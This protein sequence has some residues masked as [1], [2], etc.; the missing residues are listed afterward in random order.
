MIENKCPHCGASMAAFWHRLTPGL[1]GALIKAIEFV[2]KN[3][4]NEFNL[5]Q[6]D[7]SK[8]EYNNFQ[9]LRFHALVAKVQDKKGSWLIT[10]RGGQF[11]RGEIGVPTEVQTFRNRVISHSDQKVGIGNFKGRY[12]EFQSQFAYEVKPILSPLQLEQQNLL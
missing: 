4:K 5:S 2:K 12:P 11:L 1:V 9:K 10:T 7:L 8:G 3:N 6:L